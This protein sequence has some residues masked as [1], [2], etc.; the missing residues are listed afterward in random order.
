MLGCYYLAYSMEYMACN[1][2]HLQFV[3]V[4]YRYMYMAC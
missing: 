3:Q 4:Q 2:M 1:M